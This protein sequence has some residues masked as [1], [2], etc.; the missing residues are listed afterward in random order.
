MSDTGKTLALIQATLP[1]VTGPKI[2]AEVDDWLDDHITNPSSP[3]LDT[4]L[5][6]SSSAAPANLVGDLKS[7]LDAEALGTLGKIIA[8]KSYN[9]TTTSES[10]YRS[11]IPATIVK[12][13]AYA[14]HLFANQY[15]GKAQSSPYPT[16]RLYTS[17]AETNDSIVDS[18]F[19][20]D[21]IATDKHYVIPF[22]A[23][24]NANYVYVYLN[25]MAGTLDIDV[26]LTG[27]IG[28]D[29]KE[30]Q[31][32][33][34]VI[35]GEL[36]ELGAEPLKNLYKYSDITPDVRIRTDTGET[37]GLNTFSTSDY[38]Q[39][40]E[41]TA[42]IINFSWYSSGNYGL[43]FYNSSKTFIENSGIKQANNSDAGSFDPFI[44]NSISGA[45]YVRFSIPDSRNP[46]SVT[47]KKYIYTVTEKADK[48]MYTIPA[49]F[50]FDNIFTEDN[51]TVG[52][53]TL[54]DAQ[55]SCIMGDS[56]IYAMRFNGSDTGNTMLVK[57]D[58]ETNTVTDRVQD[59]SYGHA[60]GIA[61]IESQDKLFI[62]A[63]D[64][65]GTIYTVDPDTL[66][67]E[68]SFSLEEVLSPLITDY[69]GVGGVAY[70]KEIDKILF[71]IRGTKKG[72]AVFDSSM[73]FEKIIWID[74]I[75]NYTFGDIS[76]DENFIYTTQYN[77]T[78]NNNKLVLYDYRG[79]IVS[80][81]PF[82][83][84]NEPEGAMKYGKDIIAVFNQ[85]NKVWIYKCTPINTEIPIAKVLS[86]YYP[87]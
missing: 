87:F 24:A 26:S 8:S 50:T 25:T 52:E 53:Y 76:A 23:S 12:N 80:K 38:I 70:A 78:T 30:L 67:Y 61:Y 35:H 28:N 20:A 60:N 65:A 34:V 22:I 2:I 66:E 36:Q 40:E 71:L 31:D 75:K 15:Q 18:V 11:W 59:H 51:S 27:G 3:P 46:E 21:S 16:I 77:G 47:M 10:V 82:I 57:Y 19:D 85:D 74:Y 6:S 56:L 44:F 48:S 5:S 86:Q 49:S 14:I 9:R 33:N 7:H 42:Y 43:A 69:T 79:N 13:K 81:T 68:S 58:L 64:N 37:E 4:S 39:V 72:F 73:N 41:N 54:L 17:T 83:V 84:K 29:V 55:G 32:D 1:G 62:V 63:L 45:K